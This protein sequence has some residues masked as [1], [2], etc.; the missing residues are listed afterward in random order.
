MQQLWPQIVVCKS[1]V[2]FTLLNSF[3]MKWFKILN[4]AQRL[5][6]FVLRDLIVGAKAMSWSNMKQNRRCWNILVLDLVIASKMWDTA[7]LLIPQHPITP[8][9][10]SVWNCVPLP[11]SLF[12]GSQLTHNFS[13]NY[14][15]HT[16][17]LAQTHTHTHTRTRPSA[18]SVA[19]CLLI[20]PGQ[21]DTVQQTS[22]IS[23]KD[24]SS[25]NH[26]DLPKNTTESSQ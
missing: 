13:L 8:G 9:R 15:A 25:S 22:N 16:L 19:I 12:P 24:H 6:G 26:N 14:R 20:F 21:A 11:G 23:D 17:P 18:I 2:Q 5:K 3:Y 10:L 1:K 4:R 7:C